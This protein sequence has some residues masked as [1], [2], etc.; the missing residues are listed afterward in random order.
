MTTVRIELPIIPASKME[1]KHIDYFESAALELIS[2]NKYFHFDIANHPKIIPTI[3]GVTNT[4]REYYS[5]IG[6]VWTSAIIFDIEIPDK[7]VSSYFSIDS[8]Y[9]ESEEEWI[10]HYQA[11]LIMDICLQ[12]FHLTVFSNISKPGALKIAQGQVTLDGEKHSNT[13]KGYS[14]HRETLDEIKSLDWIKY[15]SLD[16]KE[17]IDWFRNNNFSYSRF[18]TNSTE[19]ALNAFTKLFSKNNDN[20]VFDL[21]WSLVGVE[22]LF[23][24]SKEGISQQI[25]D[26]TQVLFG[27]LTSFKKKLK[28]MYNYRSRLVHGDLDFAPEN[29]ESIHDH[30]EKIED[31]FFQASW[32]AVAILTGALQELV[33]RNITNFEFRYQLTQ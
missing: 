8:T 4:S 32:L 12:L 14:I 19:R 18:S 2:L 5:V 24:D 22:T 13:I 6:K 3:S 30:E 33:S 20:I 7:P 15:K 9:Y 28:Y 17:V 29:Y 1:I 23:C 11:E 27:E 26:K 31:E 25:F 10:D 16:L 21:L